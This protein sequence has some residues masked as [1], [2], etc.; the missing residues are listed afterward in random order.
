[1]KLLIAEWTLFIQAHEF[2]FSEKYEKE[3]L[4]KCKLPTAPKITE[5]QN[6]KLVSYSSSS[7]SDEESEQLTVV[8][9]KIETSDYLKERAS[10]TISILINLKQGIQ[11]LVDVKEFPYNVEPLLK[12]LKR[13]SD[14]NVLLT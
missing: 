2:L 5:D 1:M 14:K 4:F 13:C 7:S 3:L 10:Q 6:R 11:K 8:D 12:L 9:K